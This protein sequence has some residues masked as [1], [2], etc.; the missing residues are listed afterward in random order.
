MILFLEGAL[1]PS[2]V[3]CLSISQA[4]EAFRKMAQ[5]RYTGKL[6]LTLQESS[7]Q[8]RVPASSS[9]VIRADGSYLVTG[10][11][12]GLGLSV[13][14][15]LAARG[16]GHLV[17]VGRSGAASAEQQAAVAGLEA[18]GAR[19]TVAKADIADRAQVERVLGEVAA[20][21]MPLRGL[22]HAAGIL[23]DGLLQQQTPERFRAVMAPK[24]MGALHLHA[25][26]SKAPLDFFVLYASAAGLLGSPG[27]GNYAA[28]NTF[29][30]ALAH[31][32]RARGLSGLSIDWGVFSEV[33]LAAAQENRGARL[34]SRGMRNLTPGEGLWALERLLDSDRPQ[35]GVVPLDMRQWVE[36]Y[37]AAAS[38]R[39][40]SPLAAAP[41]SGAHGPAGDQGLLARLAAAEP[42]ARARLLEEVL[43]AQASQVLRIPEDKLDADAPFTSLGMDSLM[44][45]ELRNRIESTLG[46]NIPVTLLWTYPTVVSLSK[47]LAQGGLLLTGGAPQPPVE[48]EAGAVADEVANLDDNNLMAFIDGLLDRANDEGLT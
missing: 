20:T 44:G 10:G 32:R 27:Q 4:P 21:G 33:G 40:L 17:L 12:G 30:D 36:F 29:L 25:L 5:A 18:R 16:A 31:H 41:R 48:P 6:V 14:G 37:P 45:L 38:S 26:T 22:V 39:V 28:A 13:A 19:V 1:A 2:P 23:D 42:G 8:I 9:A 34:A 3:E 35:V 47:H 24:V 11:L 7:V 46:I 43:R 15:W